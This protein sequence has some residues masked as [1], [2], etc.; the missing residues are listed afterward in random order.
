MTPPAPSPPVDFPVY[1]VAGDWRYRWFE[2]F[3]AQIGHPTWGVRLGHR[4]ADGSAY[5]GLATL[6]RERYD[7]STGSRPEEVPFYGTH[8]LVNITL[9]ADDVP[10]PAGFLRALVD[11][12]TVESQRSASWPKVTWS[13]DGV[14]VSAAQWS[15]AGGWT[16]YT[17]ELPDVY[18][19]AVGFGVPAEP[20]TCEHLTDATP[21][22]F[23]LAAPIS[24][25]DLARI[26][27]EQGP[28][29][30]VHTNADRFHPDHEPLLSTGSAGR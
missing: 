19:V 3:D 5:V 12:E 16:A 14:S 11:H 10:R 22:G 28:P 2:F 26:Q 17:A 30:Y 8:W 23:D 18:L 9:P 27:D 7:R 20:L 6:P 13:V 4:T 15:F 1:G 25:A 24:L 21:Y 29:D